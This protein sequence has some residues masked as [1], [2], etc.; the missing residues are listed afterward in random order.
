M[1]TSLIPY[2]GM[3]Y[4]WNAGMMGVTA[5]NHWYVGVIQSNT[6]TPALSH[7][8]AANLASM[9][10]TNAFGASRLELTGTVS[11][12]IFDATATPVEFTNSSGSA[13]TAYGIFVCSNPT[14]GSSSGTL[15]GVYMFTT[16][17]TIDNAEILRV[18]VTF[19]LSN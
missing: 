12:G 2:E 14:V 8:L 19:P 18:P 4:L 5:T 7:T 13:K 6:Y 1:A 3:N 16:A 17:K 15:L 9:S 10:E 11:N